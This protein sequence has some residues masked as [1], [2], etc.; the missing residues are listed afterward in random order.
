MASERPAERPTRNFPPLLWIIVALVV[1][2]LGVSF[3]YRRGEHVTPS[4]GT[5]PQAPERPAIMPPA[6]DA[7][8]TP[9]SVVVPSETR[10]SN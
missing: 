8:A 7:P 4:G 5:M 3:V 6:S 2:A 10:P 1:V 9:G